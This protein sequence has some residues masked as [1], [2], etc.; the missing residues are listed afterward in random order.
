MTTVNIAGPV[1]PDGQR[2]GVLRIAVSN[3]GATGS[4]DVELTSLGL[5]LEDSEGTAIAA[6]AAGNLLNAIE[7]YA[8][9]D[10]SGDFDPSADTLIAMVIAPAPAGD[11]TL[12]IT[13]ADT[14]PADVRIAAGQSRNYFVVVRLTA[15]A[16]AQSP[17]AL[18]LTHITNGPAGSTAREAGSETPLT[19]VPIADGSSSVVTAIFDTA[20]TTS[21]IA[22]V[23]AFDP[24]TPARIPLFFAFHDAEDTP[25]QLKYEITGISNPGLFAFAGID[26]L[27]GVLALDYNAGVTGSSQFTIRA[28][29]SAGKTVSATSSVTLAPMRTYA[30]W[31]ALQ[32][33]AANAQGS[34]AGEDRTGAGVSNLVKYA[35]ALDPKKPGDRAGLPRL[36][37]NGNAR[38]FTHLKPK[39]A[40][41]IE[42]SYEISP[43]MAV[44]QP[45][46]N[47]VHFYQNTTD[48]SDGRVR[49][50]LLLLVDW[51]RVFVR[52]R[53]LAMLSDYSNWAAFQ[54]GAGNPAGGAAGDDPANTGMSNFAR[55]AFALDPHNASDRAGLPRLDRGGDAWV[56]THLKPTY[57]ADLA[58]G[59]E[60]SSDLA[61]WE[62]AMDGV[63]FHQSTKDLGDG[64][65]RVDLQLLVDWPRAF[66]RARAN[67]IAVAPRTATGGAAAPPFTASQNAAQ[68]MESPASPARGMAAGTSTGQPIHGTAVFSQETVLTTAAVYANSVAIADLDGDGFPDVLSAS[69]LDNKVAWY[70]NNGDGTFG[71]QQVIT[72]ANWEPS[73]VAVADLDGDGKPDVITGSHFPFSNSTLAWHKNLGGGVFGPQQIISTGYSYISSITVADLDNDGKPDLICTSL[74]DNQIAWHKNLGGGVF[75]PN[76]VIGVLSGSAA[77]KGPYQAVAA[78]LDGDGFPDIVTASTTDNKIAWY[79]NN[80]DGTFGSQQVIS[81]SVLR[82]SCVAVAD[83]DGDGRMDVIA[84]GANDNTVSFFKNNG[85]GTFGPRVVLSSNARGVFSVIAADLNG[86]GAPDVVSASLGDNKIAWHENLGGGTFGPQQIISTNADNAVAV[87]AADLNG[88]G[89]ID[90]VSASQADSKIA[91]YLNSGSQAALVTTDTA[92]PALVEGTRGSLLRM[93]LTNRGHPGDD[94]ARLAALALLFESSAGVPLTTAQ[95]N[96]LIDSVQI[97]ADTNGSGVFD[98][99]SDRLVQTILFLPLNEGVLRVPLPSGSPDLPVQPG[100]TRNFFVVVTM[101]PD[102]AAQAPGSFRV[103]NLTSGPVR[104]IAKD[105]LSGAVVA[106][107]SVANTASSFVT[108]QPNQRPVATAIPPVTVFDAVAPTGIPLRQFFNDAEDGPAG[109][110]YAITGNSN[111]GLFAFAGI[112][113]ATGVLLLKYRPDTGG[114]AQVTVRATDTLGKSVSTTFAV[115]A[116]L[117]TSI[118][119]WTNL[120]GGGDSLAPQEAVS[121]LMDYA[122][123]LEPSV[124]G[125]PGGLPQMHSVGRARLLSHLKPRYATDLAYTYEVSSDLVTWS[126]AINGIHYYGFTT[127]LPNALQQKDLVI[128]LDWPQVFLRVRAALIP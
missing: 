43:D 79:R 128:L 2:G 28:T 96:S 67:Q 118:A 59:Y 124:P 72:T 93:A 41:D 76:Q 48:L 75:G 46:T 78:D 112:N 58:Y 26:P 94:S 6:A 90:V 80:G 33:G 83:F 125:R 34:A 8:D 66:L 3:P 25:A 13:F 61:T 95:A 92:P 23:I 11:G 42:Y 74:F 17:H 88:D 116:R 102:A 87:A 38:V 123:A 64:R 114:S 84:G 81:T 55:Y 57:A 37:K 100:A 111:P 29:D 40:A 82:A 15:D 50:D 68:R 106:L 62:P 77:A 71:P 98:P 54:F 18:R 99:A 22:N 121:N 107:D 1:I 86:D 9:T 73:V 20:P 70:R 101:Q 60:I 7:L 122:F 32:L 21:G 27:T 126:P 36:E 12:A 113:P 24:A 97:Y 45:A 103:T 19:I 16:S 115:N 5:R 120:Y 35:F 49:V 91:V 104:A 65:T 51:P 105:A 10:A 89:T 47:G 44:W 4:P 39:Y 117:I 14:D 108:A 110:A 127:D 109:L 119:D 30:D 85:D 56:F 31:A 69:L 52:T 53:V 63:H